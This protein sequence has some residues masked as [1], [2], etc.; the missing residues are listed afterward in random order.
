M[1]PRTRRCVALLALLA[2]CGVV[3]AGPAGA[4]SGDPD[5]PW[6]ANPGDAVYEYSVTPERDPARWAALMSAGQAVA[7][8]QIPRRQLRSMTTSELLAAVLDYPLL[9]NF[10]AYD[11]PQEGLVT[12]TRESAALGELLRREDTPRVVV[13]AYS[14]VDLVRMAQTEDFP[15][16]EIAFLELLLAQPEILDRLSQEGRR[17]LVSAVLDQWA[18]KQSAFAEPVYGEAGSALVV[19]R[20]LSRDSAEFAARARADVAAASFIESG[21]QAATGPTLGMPAAGALVAG[22]QI[23]YGLDQVGLAEPSPSLS[24]ERGS[25]DVRAVPMLEPG[26]VNVYTPKDTPV[27]VTISVREPLTAVQIQENN[28]W[29]MRSYPNAVMLRG[30]TG[31]YNCH[32]YAWHSQ[33]TSNRAWM[34]N[35]SA[36]MTDGS[37]RR[38]VSTG[39]V[40]TVPSAAPVN[41]RVFYVGGNHSAIRFSSTRVVSKWGV[42][43]LMRHAPNYTPYFTTTGLTYW[44]A[45]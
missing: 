24:G 22:L 29:I 14:T 1:G 38:V 18:V 9:G 5:R 39:Y 19:M 27:A 42:Y 25:A 34:N 44:T 17:G 8:L 31:M 4:S 43:G 15:T 20:S 23:A 33:A 30:S 32:S 21:A 35:P 45:S 12:L 2:S 13:E 10:Q 16:I 11:S 28:M 40:S 36:Y 26:Q 37:Y 6:F 7:A 41:A 3:S